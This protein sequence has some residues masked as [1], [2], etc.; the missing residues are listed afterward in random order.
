MRKMTAILAVIIAIAFV[1]SAMAVAPGKKAEFQTSMGKV[2]FDG[3]THSVNKCAEC[4]PKL[5]PMKKGGFKMP[6][7]DHVPGKLCGTCHDGT[8][9]FAQDKDNCAKCHTK[10]AGGY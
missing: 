10:D 9:A 8:K 4:H 7:A 3:K 5:F 2:V 6:V 1:G